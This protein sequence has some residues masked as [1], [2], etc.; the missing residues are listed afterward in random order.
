MSDSLDVSFLQVSLEPAKRRVERMVHLRRS[1]SVPSVIK[2]PYYRLKARG[3]R[4]GFN[5]EAKLSG[6]FI[7]QIPRKNAYTDPERELHCQIG[8]TRYASRYFG[9]SLSKTLDRTYEAV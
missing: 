7:P 4:A 8:Q 9:A 1:E 5:N 3:R 2:D 6:Q